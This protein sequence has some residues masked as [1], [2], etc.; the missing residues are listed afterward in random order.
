ML[1]KIMKLA[2]FDLNVEPYDQEE[3]VIAEV[4]QDMLV[5]LS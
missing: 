5:E 1:F 3:I 2:F 4:S